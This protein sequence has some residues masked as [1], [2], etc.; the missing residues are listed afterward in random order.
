M[1]KGQ[2]SD[3]KTSH[4][5]KKGYSR[6]VIGNMAQNTFIYINNS[7]TNRLNNTIVV[8]DM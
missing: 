7:T 6:I 3:K 5:D 8:R 1:Y 2:G 4:N